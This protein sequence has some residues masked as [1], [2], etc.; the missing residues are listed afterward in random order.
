MS[1]EEQ[2][3]LA[4]A[5]ADATGLVASALDKINEKWQE[6]DK[7]V[8]KELSDAWYNENAIKV[9]PDL[10]TALNSANSGINESVKSLGDALVKAVRIWEEGNGRASGHYQTTNTKENKLNMGHT[11]LDKKGAAEGMDPARVQH[12]IDKAEEIKEAM[13][14]EG[15]AKIREAANNPAF[16][17]GSMQKNL[18]NVSDQLEASIKDGINK[19]VDGVTTNTGT[20]KRNVETATQSTESLFQI[21]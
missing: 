1:S 11:F 18:M 4:A 3:I 16:R 7:D 9:M 6:L 15:V 14:N 20:A 13:I 2:A 5:A 12:A 21:K 19:L 10:Q 8:L 17:G